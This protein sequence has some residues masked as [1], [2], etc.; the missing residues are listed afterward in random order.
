MSS[1]G[2]GGGFRFDSDRARNLPAQVAQT[3]LEASAATAGTEVANY[4]GECLKQ[5]NGRDAAATRKNLAE[6]EDHLGQELEG[7]FDI[8]FGGSIAKHTYVDGLSD[9]DA[10]LAFK[11][12]EDVDSPRK[13]LDKLTKRLADLL[14]DRADVS[15]GKL[16]VTVRYKDGVELQLIPAVRDENGMRV[17]SW[18]RDGWSTINPEKFTEALTKRNE[19]CGRRLIPTIKLAKAI[20]GTLPEEKRLTGYHVESLAIAAFRDYKGLMVLGS[21]LSY[22]MK[23]VPELLKSPISDKTGQ[24]IHVDEHLGDA[25]S[26]A[27]QDLAHLFERLSKRLDN[28]LTTGS[29]SNLGQLLGEEK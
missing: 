21:M 20:N 12:T 28:S 6:I 7:R 19:E 3:Q 9:V 1:G 17:P 2:G 22:F 15:H 24:S 18:R 25:G 5:F 29:I 16:A 26:N 23:S 13:L 10:L 14:G 27:R 4:L 11:N 8:L